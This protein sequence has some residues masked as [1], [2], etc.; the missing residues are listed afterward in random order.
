MP[1]KLTLSTKQLEDAAGFGEA[2]MKLEGF[3]PA[4]NVSYRN[5]KQEILEGRIDFEE[6]VDSAVLSFTRKSQTTAA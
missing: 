1:P 2:N 3:D 4:S 6:A 5:L